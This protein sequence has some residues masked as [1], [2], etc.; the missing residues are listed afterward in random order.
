MSS[1]TDTPLL[2]INY[3]NLN[4]CKDKIGCVIEQFVNFMVALDVTIKGLQSVKTLWGI[5]VFVLT[6]CKE[7]QFLFVLSCKL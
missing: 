1:L 7:K 4:Q 6:G 5:N 3:V 2:L